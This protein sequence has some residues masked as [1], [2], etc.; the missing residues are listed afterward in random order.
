M[1]AVAGGAGTPA[2]MAPEQVADREVGPPAD[3][4]A[5]GVMLYEALAGSRPFTGD[6][7]RVMHDKQHH[8]ALPLPED[9]AIPA[10][11]AALCRRLLAR[12]S[13]SRPDPLQ[14]AGVIAWSTLLAA[15]PPGAADQL[16]ARESQLAA[17]G[18]A[19]AA[20]DRT[21]GP[22]TAF[23]HGRS[24]EGKTS[25]AEN[26]LGTLRRDPSLVVMSGRC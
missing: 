23:I 25:L 26:F 8:E 3:W 14:I 9:P 18:E 13:S 6:M 4:Y 21:R 24:G 12:D 10:Q 22:V 16:I 2:Y 11:L 20:L 1:S 7:D 19:L 17:L 15:G 5:V